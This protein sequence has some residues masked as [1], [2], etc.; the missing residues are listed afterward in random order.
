MSGLTIEIPPG[1]TTADALSAGQYRLT[2]NAP[3]YKEDGTMVD[4]PKETI[5]T[6][7]NADVGVPESSNSVGMFG[8]TPDEI[9][10]IIEPEDHEYLEKIGV[11]G[12]RRKHRKTRKH[13]K[14]KKH[15]KSRRSRRHN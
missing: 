10:I 9:R 15:R 14:T 7:K 4:V 11:G 8:N 6:I 2:I 12:R 5:I 3:F 1:N 13:K